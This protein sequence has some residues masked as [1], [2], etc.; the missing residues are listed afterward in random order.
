MTVGWDSDLRAGPRGS[1]GGPDRPRRLQERS[2]RGAGA[3]RAP[4]PPQLRS[5]GSAHPRAVL[6]KIFWRS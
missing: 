1:R 6:R 4:T 3:W 5:Y 2:G